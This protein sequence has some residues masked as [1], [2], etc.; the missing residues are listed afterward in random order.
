MGLKDQA[1]FQI[2]YYGWATIDINI[3]ILHILSPGPHPLD[4]EDF[5]RGSGL[6]FFFFWRVL[7]NLLR[8]LAF[9]FL[10]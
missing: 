1:P 10:V 3:F 7:F 2:N 8:L 5:S 6:V 9:C 4:G